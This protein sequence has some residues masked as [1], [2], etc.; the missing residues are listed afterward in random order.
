M[1]ISNLAIGSQ[2]I[3]VTG[4]RESMSQCQVGVDTCAEELQGHVCRTVGQNLWAGR[5]AHEPEETANE[6]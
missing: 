3:S 1:S 4:L 5:H 2:L 6:P